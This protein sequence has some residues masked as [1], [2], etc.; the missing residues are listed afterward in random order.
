MLPRSHSRIDFDSDFRFGRKAKALRGV[1][2]KI[3]QLRGGGIRWGS[4][5]PVKLDHF[6]F[7]GNRFAYPCDLFFQDVEIWNRNALVFLDDNVACTKKAQAFAERQVHIK[8]DW[9]FRGV[10]S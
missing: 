3:F 9:C 10:S 7:A 5:A 4:A 8:R 6:T 2:E 1:S